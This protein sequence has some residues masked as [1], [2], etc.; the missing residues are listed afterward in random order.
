MWTHGSLPKIYLFPRTWRNLREI[1]LVCRQGEW[2]WWA[3]GQPLHT[4]PKQTK[5][6]VWASYFL[7]LWLLSRDRERKERGK[8]SK[9]KKGDKVIHERRV[10]LLKR[11]KTGEAGSWQ[12]G[13][14]EHANVNN[15]TKQNHD[16]MFSA[17]VEGE[18]VCPLHLRPWLKFFLFVMVEVENEKTKPLECTKEGRGRVYSTF[19]CGASEFRERLDLSIFFSGFLCLHKGRTAM[20]YAL[21]LFLPSS[22]PFSVCCWIEVALVLSVL[23]DE[24]LF[25]PLFF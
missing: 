20:H 18:K 21:H 15:R 4:K 2:K 5:L 23:G 25:Y 22:V 11:R 17:K 19:V 1:R 12:A 3:M 8:Q 9:K 14:Q 13:K 16:G 7:G 6:F 24:Y 10:N